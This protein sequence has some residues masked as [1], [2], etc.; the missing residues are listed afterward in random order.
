M[1]KIKIMLKRINR[2]FFFNP[3][4]SISKIA[5][6]A[7]FIIVLIGF[8]I[9][10]KPETVYKQSQENLAESKLKESQLTKEIRNKEY[11]LSQIKEESQKLKNKN[12]ELKW[13]SFLSNIATSATRT[14]DEFPTPNLVFRSNDYTI[15]EILR[16]KTFYIDLDYNRATKVYFYK[17]SPYNRLKKMVLKYQYEK[18]TIYTKEEFINF[19][20]RF[21]NFLDNNKDLIAY[22]PK[23][24]LEKQKEFNLRIKRVLKNYTINDFNLFTEKKL[25]NTDSTHMLIFHQIEAEYKNEKTKIINEILKIHKEFR[26]HTFE[27]LDLL[28]EKFFKVFETLS[29]HIIVKNHEILNY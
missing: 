7:S 8:F 25:Y 21:I 15:E 27:E 19:Q 5:T 16:R 1:K 22:S 2:S 12:L 6:S 11:T 23:N 9:Y 29:G 28:E 24:I 17:N 26:Y 4:D 10:V 18:N 20:K 3:L 13:I 14:T